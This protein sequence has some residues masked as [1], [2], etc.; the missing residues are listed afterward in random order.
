MG[1]NMKRVNSAV[2]FK[3]LGSS[4]AKHTMSEKINTRISKEQA[5]KHNASKASSHHSGD[6]HGTIEKKEDDAPTTFRS[7]AKQKQVP[8]SK[9]EKKKGTVVTGGSNAEVIND[10]EDRI[11]FLNSDIA[12]ETSIMKRG[13]MITQRNKLR[14]RLKAERLK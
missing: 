13:K 8:L 1:Y 7:P 5:D 6:P 12:E 3:E 9:H 14:A 2:P 4:P 10:L 11:E